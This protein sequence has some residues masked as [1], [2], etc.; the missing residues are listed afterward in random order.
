[1]LW[2]MQNKF[3]EIIISPA[4]LLFVPVILLIIPFPWVLAGM[5]S[6]LIHELCHIVAAKLLGKRIFCIS[7][8]S[9]GAE[10]QTDSMNLMEELIVSVTGPASCLISLLLAQHFPRFAVCSVVHSVYNLLPLYPL[11]GGRVLRCLTGRLLPQ[12]TAKQFLTTVE[13]ACMLFIVLIFIHA[14]MFFQITVLPILAGVIF[15]VRQYNRKK[16]CKGGQLRVQ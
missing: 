9:G 1:M 6:I 5:C 14:A 13:I 2:N 16:S 10:I 4:L 15:A 7:F 3:P 12:K 8:G 11:D